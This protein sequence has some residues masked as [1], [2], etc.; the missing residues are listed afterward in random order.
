MENNFTTMKN[1]GRSVLFLIA[2]LLATGCHKEQVQVYNTPNDQEQPQPVAP[3]ASMMLTN[4]ADMALPPGH[5]DMA[6]TSMPSLPPSAAASASPQLTLMLPAGWTQI[7]ASTMRVASFTVTNAQGQQADVSVVPLAGMGGGDFP[8]VNRWRGQVGLPDA[9]DAELQSASEDVETAGQP[10]KLYDIAGQSPDN[11]KPT[12]IL[13]AIQHRDDTSWYFKMM[14]DADLVEQQKPT[15]L[16][17]LKSV[18]FAAGQD[19]TPPSQPVTS[20]LSGQLPPGHPSIDD[21]GASSITTSSPGQPA[22][23][24]P[25]DWKAVDAG[26]FLVAKF[27]LSDAGGATAAVN[28]SSSSGDGGGLAANVN[29]WRGQLGLPP[30]E[31]IPTTTFAVNGGEAQLVEIS[32]TNAAT[33]QPAEIVGIMVTQPGATWFYKLMG[34]PQLIATQKDAFRRF[35][36]GVKY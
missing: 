1:T 11:H 20:D 19:Q 8:N 31:E 18:S 22:W 35:V 23:Q 14:G 10:A 5:P 6:S 15:F 28:V 36:E 33:S 26:S 29:R 17:F 4:P 9:S 27:Q 7:P 12:R 30:I 13:A 21:N 32:G 25:P 24:V 2:L 34:A 3:P 16:R